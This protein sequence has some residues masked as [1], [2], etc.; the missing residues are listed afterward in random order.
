VNRL[1]GKVAIVT[2]AAQGIGAAYARALAAEGA[3][4]ALTDVLD[5]GAAADAIIDA[6]GKALALRTDVTNAAAVQEL[7]QRTE[8]TFGG[9]DILVNNAAIF[10]SLDRAPF[11]QIASADWDRVM[12][13]NTRGPFE[14]TKAV[15]PAMRTRGGGKIV[16]IASSTF[17]TGQPGF[18]HYVAS[19]GAVIAM[20]RVLAR[21]LGGDSITVNCIAP[22]LTMSEGILRT[23]GTHNTQ[24][25]IAGRAL[26][27][28]QQPDDLLGTL[29]F[30]SS[31]ESDFI[32]GQVIV[33]DG[34][35]VM[36]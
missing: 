25:V 10:A 2:G 6:G 33:V 14:C 7:V 31:R 12:T 1:D 32:T 19:K 29:V 16:N 11:D 3:R 9:I 18:L 5:C 21:E 36:H 34:G 20:T 23:Y 15:V 22:G 30:L 4:V 24:P 35:G 8:E 26:K 13:V 27:R 17:F 28:L